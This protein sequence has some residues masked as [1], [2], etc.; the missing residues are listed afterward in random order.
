MRGEGSNISQAIETN[1]NQLYGQLEKALAGDKLSQDSLL[2]NPMLSAELKGFINSGANLSA[3][4]QAQMLSQVKTS[5]AEQAKTLAEGLDH[6][7]KQG[8]AVSIR[9][10]FVI[11][12]WVIVLGS[13]IVLLIPDQTLRKRMQGSP[14]K[15]E[16]LA[17]AHD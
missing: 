9:F 12:F 17:P 4:Q 1:L 7:I 5:L 11:S 13:A 8:F 14:E 3:E 2:A 15:A 6:G 16:V 10:L